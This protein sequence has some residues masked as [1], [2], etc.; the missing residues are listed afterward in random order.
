MCFVLILENEN[1]RMSKNIL[2]AVERLPFFHLSFVCK[3]ILILLY[4]FNII[5]PKTVNKFTFQPPLH[6]STKIL[7]TS[8]CHNSP[9]RLAKNLRSGKPS[10]GTIRIPYNKNYFG[11]ARSLMPSLDFTKFKNLQKKYP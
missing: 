5:F 10:A 1:I 7:L 9:N 4:L 8:A 2:S 3:M 11:D 6:G